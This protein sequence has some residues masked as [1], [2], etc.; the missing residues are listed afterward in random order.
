[1]VVM[2]VC[3]SGV[4]GGDECVS[5]ICG[6]VGDVCVVIGGV[7]GFCGGVVSLSLLRCGF[8]LCGSGVGG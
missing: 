7:M 3:L 1:M 6:G 2:C 8:C 5:G 4:C